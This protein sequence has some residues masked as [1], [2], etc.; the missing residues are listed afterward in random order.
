MIRFQSIQPPGQMHPQL[1]H[2]EAVQQGLQHLG[3]PCQ[4]QALAVRHHGLETKVLLH[5]PLHFLGRIPTRIAGIDN[6]Q[7][8][9]AGF[10]HVADGFALCSNVVL[11]GNVRN[12]AVSGHHQA[13]G[14]VVFHHLLGSQ[15]RRFRHG[16]FMVKPG[17]GHHPGRA[18]LLR[19][20]SAVNHVAHGIDEPNPQSGGAVGRNLHRLFRDELGF[21]G[22]N[23]LSR[24]ALGQLIPGPFLA[25]GVVNTG[26]HQFFHDPLDEGGLSGSHRAN[27]T[28]IDISAGSHSNVLINRIHSQPPLPAENPPAMGLPQG[29]SG[30]WQIEPG[31]FLPSNAPC[32]EQPG[33]FPGKAKDF[34]KKVFDK[35]EETLYN[36]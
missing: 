9:L 22:H 6:H 35:R 26:D 13:D 33:L 30:P 19:P 36:I 1:G 27:H 2:G 25:I 24:A 10:L 28:D 4:V 11:P 12:G 32:R 7:E 29:M 20:H 5:L 21:R 18:I 15:L 8:G 3:N 17:R 14:A 16:N 34:V 23:G 31:T